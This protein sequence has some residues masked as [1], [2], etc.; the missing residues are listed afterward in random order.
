[1]CTELNITHPSWLPIDSD[2][3]YL[4]ECVHKINEYDQILTN[5]QYGL[6][7][8][9]SRIYFMRVL[10][11]FIAKYEDSVCS[12]L[13]NLPVRTRSDSKVFEET[14]SIVLDNYYHVIDIANNLQ[15]K[16]AGLCMYPYPY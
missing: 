16:V 14:I 4:S 12:L 1:M 15:H 13:R 3:K 7:N 10:D 6:F 11:L 5:F 8:R 9:A 2:L